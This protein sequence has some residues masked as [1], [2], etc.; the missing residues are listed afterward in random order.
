MFA[1]L[2]S[3]TLLEIRLS[4]EENY[5]PK[6]L[7]LLLCGLLRHPRSINSKFS[8]Q[9]SSTYKPL[10]GQWNPTSINCILLVL[11]EKEIMSWC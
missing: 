9:R 8:G 1:P 2:L 4:N 6:T 3:G 11:E 10:T 5:P 7:H